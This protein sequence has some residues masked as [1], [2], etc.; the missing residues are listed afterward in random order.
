MSGEPPRK[1]IKTNE[2]STIAAGSSAGLQKSVQ[3]TTESYVLAEYNSVGN[4]NNN[5]RTF[6]ANSPVSPNRVANKAGRNGKSPKRPGNPSGVHWTQHWDS[7]LQNEGQMG[8]LSYDQSQSIPPP[9]AF[10]FLDD[11]RS[12]QHA[13]VRNAHSRTVPSKPKNSGTFIGPMIPTTSHYA[14]TDAPNFR[15]GVSPISGEGSKKRKKRA[16]KPSNADNSNSFRDGTNDWKKRQNNKPRPSMNLGQDWDDSA[17]IDA[18][19]AAEA[20]YRVGSSLCI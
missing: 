12:V 18:W 8:G 7:Q 15:G 10:H 16:K 2:T 6:A 1:R 5:Q 17:L 14:H 19:N 13:N 11:K 9:V 20:Q 3:N 4:L